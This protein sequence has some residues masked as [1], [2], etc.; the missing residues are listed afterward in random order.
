[1]GRA[2]DDSRY[3]WSVMSDVGEENS[4]R[5]RPR[6]IARSSW[7]A[8]GGVALSRGGE[9][10]SGRRRYWGVSAREKGVGMSGCVCVAM[11][12]VSN[13]LILIVK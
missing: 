6:A 2:S 7:S 1:M 3:S 11:V 13:S 8:S 12:C 9:E 10:E 4:A 5:L